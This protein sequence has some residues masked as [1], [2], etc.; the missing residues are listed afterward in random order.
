MAG[1]GIAGM[2]SRGFR[3]FFEEHGFIISLMSVRPRTMYQNGVHKDWLRRTREDYWQQELQDIGQEV[4][5]NKEVYQDQTS[6]TFGYN[7]RYSTYKHKPSGVAGEFRSTL[8]TWHYGRIFA[9][10][11]TLNQSFIECDAS[12]RVN[13][14]TSANV[15]WVMCRHSIQARRLV[16]RTGIGKIL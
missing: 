7:D 1:H 11:Q 16:K 6:G 15:L 9:G 2:R 3:R 13:Q 5:D 10:N 8:N 4:I 12:K 14:V